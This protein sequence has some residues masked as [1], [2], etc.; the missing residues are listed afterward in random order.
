[1]VFWQKQHLNWTLMDDEIL[2]VKELLFETVEIA[3]PIGK[4]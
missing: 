3:K 1:M 2:S 4:H